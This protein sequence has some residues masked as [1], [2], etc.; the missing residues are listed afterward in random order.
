MRGLRLLIVGVAEKGD[1]LE[2]CIC[3]VPRVVQG[4]RMSVKYR[5]STVVTGVKRR[6]GG[7]YVRSGGPGISGLT[8]Y[9]PQQS[10]G[11]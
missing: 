6:R 7:H 5:E 9:I 11:M 2:F 3:E 4:L 10:T 8:L 1:V